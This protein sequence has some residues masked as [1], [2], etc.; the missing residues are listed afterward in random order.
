MGA[1]EST[2]LVDFRILGSL[3]AVREERRLEIKP[4]KAR[5]LLA[6]LLL[7]P[8]RPVSADRL[9][10]E[11]WGEEPPSS[12][13][14]SLRVL[15][16]RLRETLAA[17][18]A[19]EAIRTRSPGYALCVKDSQIDARRFEALLARGRDEL[20]RGDPHAATTIL[21]DAL[22]LW[23]G[24]ALTNVSDSLAI[25][26]E[27]ARLE[28]L[29]TVALE[30]RIDADLACARH[31][32]VAGELEQL[33]R[34]HP[35]RE[36][37][38]R[39]LMLALYRCGRQADALAAF[40][41][42]RE[43]L[44]DELGIE[45]SPTLRELH[46]RMLEQSPE[47]SLPAPEARATRQSPADQPL[48]TGVVTFLLTDV[49]GS[50]QLW[51]RDARAMAAAIARLEKIV[52]QAVVR[53]RGALVKSRGE[54]DSTFSVF[55]RATDA[56]RAALELQAQLAT[57]VWP[58][59]VQLKLRMALHTGEAQERDADYFGAA[60]NRAARLRSLAQPGQVIVSEATAQVAGDQLPEGA[61]LL[62]LGHRGLRGLERD[63]HVFEL[64]GIAATPADAPPE[65]DRELPKDLSAAGTLFVGRRTELDTLTGLWQ[66]AVEG[67]LRLALIAGEPGIGKTRLAG[68][69]AR[70]AHEEG[71]VVLF[72]RCDEDLGVPYQPFTEALRSYVVACPTREL[73]VQAGRQAGELARLVPEVGDR[74]LGARPV[75]A[76]ELEEQRDR[77]FN[78]VASLLAAASRSRPLLL[79]LDDL[80][81]A[82]KPTLL[83]L[84]HLLR[85]RE[86]TRLLV[87]GTYRDTEL[88]RAHPL[89]EVL[90]DLRRDPTPIDRLRLRG[91]DADAVGDYV[92]AT[93]GQT[94]EAQDAEFARTLHE[95]T[96][97]NPFFIG[98]VLRHLAESGL[99]ERA[100]GR[101][102]TSAAIADVGLPEGVK[103]VIA[104]RL[105]RLSEAANRALAVAA[106]L[107]QT[108]SL[109]VLELVP[110]AGENPDLLLDAIEE[111]LRAGLVSETGPSS[112]SFSHAL[113]RQAL[114]A[115]LT[116]TRRARLHRRVGE[117]IELSADADAQVEALA[118]HFAEAA[119]DGQIAK[120]ADYALAAG[121]RA[122]D[123]LASE[124]AVVRL[125]RGLELLDLQTTAD[126]ARRSDLLRGLARAR[127][128]L[129][130]L[131]G[132]H[133]ATLAA[134]E[135]AR[136]VGSAER[137][138]QVALVYWSTA[139]TGVRD[140]V[141]P[142]LSEEALYS[143]GEAEPAL[144][145]RLLARLV[146][147]RAVAES[148]GYALG[149]QA[150][151]AL[152]LARETGDP[153]ALTAA[154]GVRIRLLYGTERVAER[155][156]LAHQLLRL[157]VAQGDQRAVLAA[158][159]Y[160]L[161]AHFEIA[162]R[163]AY[164]TDVA[165][166]ACRAAEVDTRM[167][168]NLLAG[169]GAMR[170]LFEGQFGV[171]AQLSAE[172][173]ELSGG[174][175]D[176]VSA[177][178][179]RTALVSSEEGRFNEAIDRVQE[180]AERTDGH[181]VAY[182]RITT[183]QARSGDLDA[184]R[185]GLHRLTSGDLVAVP[186]DHLWQ[187]VLSDLAETSGHL[188]DIERAARIYD[189]LGPHRGLLP[190]TG[191]HMCF[192]AVDR[193]L[194]ILAATLGRLEEAAG[195]YEAA[196]ELEERMKA[197][198]LAARTR[199]WYAR[200]LLER[201]GPAD[202]DHA[203]RLLQDALAIAEQLGMAPLATDSKAL[204]RSP[205]P[206]VT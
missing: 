192:G 9:V 115:E 168:R 201:G 188:R 50:S 25:S 165:E 117:A 70:R 98:E 16:S 173:V 57:E 32:L 40:S 52:R 116:A 189:Y 91:L 97:G 31:D 169:T 175:A 132:N 137:L 103:E 166:L 95:S 200:A 113:I 47:L 104:R 17:A 69:L 112:Y 49:E 158:V 154:L 75:G 161:D 87:L 197:R 82:A 107:G 51:E 155:L 35:F 86:S 127:R 33:V 163:T 195:H 100:G 29:R 128:E 183:L 142:E 111:A 180:W 4:A 74:L 56:V 48:P 30:E 136:A 205:H 148:R 140:P 114:Y 81:W 153:N 206:T 178:A 139:G 203:S 39:A 60:V 44:V 129:G 27:A 79:V 46:Q 179:A 62:D 12:A 2:G 187:G 102:I 170:A 146:H 196:L 124:E 22:A 133:R 6:L 23:R 156:S 151:Q 14:V 1:G 185:A 174:R 76:G 119:L 94:L 92:A 109:P 73:A 149:E 67:S 131:E 193:F 63:E 64:R 125:E 93:G 190:T 141:V 143:L 182:A 159:A 38:W 71:A 78:A 7:D 126:P 42:L 90:A 54:G 24:P 18:G 118:Y 160:S 77:L 96:D 37:L 11:L 181:S 5:T 172:A 191:G 150:E 83:M 26:G 145:A 164:D 157:G 34:T 138:A 99:L 84:R 21:R 13:A 55:A 8:G 10:D 58:S 88:D 106:V 177:H 20:A 45:P 85:L 15:V 135:D 120:A 123:R 162:D 108:F 130:D 89:A 41:E 134:V 105:S 186:R 199:Y 3:E 59:E 61:E 19:P 122:L 110:D 144:R 204:L 147:Y 72:G 121:D 152:A 198:P 53:A 36:R 167:A 171:V 66:M 101:W 68:E 65:F 202:H 28:E 176:A 184:A 80:Q 194:G 43:R